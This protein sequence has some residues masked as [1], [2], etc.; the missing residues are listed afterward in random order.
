MR[1]VF[2]LPCRS[3]R[4]NA[5]DVDDELRCHFDMRVAELIARRGMTATAARE[6][7]LRRF[8]DV[9]DARRHATREARGTRCAKRGFERRV[10]GSRPSAPLQHALR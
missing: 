4:A 3:A 7:A 9:D 6:E 2:R 5:A 10:N 1:R 8:G